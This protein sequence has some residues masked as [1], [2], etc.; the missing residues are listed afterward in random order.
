[1]NLHQQF[2]KLSFDI[3]KMKNKLIS[4]L[5][6]IYEKEIY[7]KHGC[8]TIHEYGFKYAKLSKEMVDKAVRTLR[9]L[10]NKPFLKQVI[11]TQGIHKVA[12]VATIATPENEKIFAKHV[13]NMSKPALFEFAKELRSKSDGKNLLNVS[14]FGENLEKKPV[15]QFCRAI[16]SKMQIELD[17][18]MQAI[19]LRLKKNLRKK[20]GF[21]LSNKEALKIMLK[22]LEQA[23][24]PEN[25]KENCEEKKMQNE[26]SQIKKSYEQQNNKNLPDQNYVPG[27][28]KEEAIVI[29]TRYIRARRKREIHQKYDNK[30]AY[31]GCIKPIEEIHHRIPFAFERSHESAIPLCKIH[32]EFSHNGL[33]THELREP[34]NWKLKMNGGGSVFDQ[35]YIAK[36]SESSSRRDST[37]FDS[38]DFSVTMSL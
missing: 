5:L 35:F 11:E 38:G 26:N 25:G 37:K 33:I 29:P 31:P 22:K 24:I 21:E 32:H 13:E 10:E 12:L 4:L 3:I 9:H 17:E 30:C 34:E 7:K 28:G 36:R 20:S 2:V 18:E 6:E 23:N 16:P 19:F 27:N 1:M 8:R 14:L 15:G